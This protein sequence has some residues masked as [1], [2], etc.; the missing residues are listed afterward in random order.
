MNLIT[1]AT[2]WLLCSETDTHNKNTSEIFL[3]G[4]LFNDTGFTAISTQ[5]RKTRRNVGNKI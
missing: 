4:V 1:D 5:M 2:V 3:R